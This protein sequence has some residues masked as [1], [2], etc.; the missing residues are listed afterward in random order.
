MKYRNDF[1]LTQCLFKRINKMAAGYGGYFSD[2][3]VNNKALDN[4]R[5]QFPSHL[6]W[7]LFL[8]LIKL[9]K[10]NLS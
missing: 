8:L 10:N 1:S 3:V 5:K 7:Q 6:F 9:G 4:N 2:S